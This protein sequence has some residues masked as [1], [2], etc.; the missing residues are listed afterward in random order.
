MKISIETDE[1]IKDTEIY[2]KCP[3]LTP[4]IEKVL[5]MLRMLDAKLTG[6]K[7]GETYILDNADIL[8]IDT[9]D[10]RTFLYADT[11][12]YETTLRLYELEEKL[13]ASFFR[14]NKS[15]IINMRHIESMRTDLE[16]R[17]KV[18]MSNGEKLMVSRQYAQAV[19]K[20]LEVR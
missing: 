11:E 10:K 20:K 4:E 3:N 14:A 18:T 1:S 17:L 9:A 12:I 15:C 7:D 13:P 19:K 8:Y 2:I 6:V 16:G 5:S